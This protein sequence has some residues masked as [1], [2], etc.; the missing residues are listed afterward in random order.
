M[1]ELNDIV[2]VSRWATK[3]MHEPVGPFSERGAWRYV[4]SA[5]QCVLSV[6]AR[7]KGKP[8]ARVFASTPEKPI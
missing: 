3:M 4:Q 8:V 7:E 1:V 5:F 2:I 6:C